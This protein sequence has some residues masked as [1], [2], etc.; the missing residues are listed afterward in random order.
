MITAFGVK[1][2]KISMLDYVK[3][4]LTAFDKAEPK[5]AGTK[6]SAAPNNFF[7]VKEDC[8]KVSAVKTVQ[9]HSLVAKTLYA[10]KRATRWD[11]C[12][13]IYFLTKRV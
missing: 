1:S 9:F 11:T 13:S 4:I 12:T 6:S 10:T 5:G 3:E 8:E 2:L 7:T